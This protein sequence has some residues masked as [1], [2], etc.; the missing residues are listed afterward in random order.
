MS[1]FRMNQKVRH[2][3][4]GNVYKIVGTPETVRIEHLATPAYAYV[5]EDWKLIWI[6]PQTEMEDGR[7]EV[8]G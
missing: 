4:T 2:I 7:F 1:M 3:K 8:V 6:R 5:P